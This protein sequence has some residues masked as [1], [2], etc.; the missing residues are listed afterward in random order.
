MISRRAGTAK[1]VYDIGARLLTVAFS[2]FLAIPA[3]GS[4]FADDA[5][6]SRWENRPLAERPTPFDSDEDA[7]FFPALD[8]FL[9]DHF[10]FAL[11]LN[12]WHRQLLFYFFKDSPSRD[13]SL[14]KDGYVFVTS[15]QSAPFS[16]LD[17]LCVRGMDANVA[18]TAAAAW[19]Q[20]LDHFSGMH[21][22]VALIIVPSKPT[23]YPEKLTLS[24]PRRYREA[25]AQYASAQS[26]SG[27]IARAAQANGNRV[28][29]PY[30]EFLRQKYD[31]NFYPRENFHY[32][33]ASAHWVGREVLQQ[34]GIAVSDEFEEKVQ[35]MFRT[36]DLMNLLGFTRQIQAISYP[37]TAFALKKKWGNPSFVLDYYKRAQ[38]SQ[39]VTINSGNPLSSRTALSVGNSFSQNTADNLAPGYR[40]L[41]NVQINDLK[42]EEFV[43]FFTELVP[44]VAANDLIFV[45]NES[46]APNAALSWAAELRRAG[47]LSNASAP[48]QR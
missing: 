1:Y 35:G 38:A 42:K 16:T 10:G 45:F 48:G 20:I 8:R 17:R 3:V 34:L 28:I 44:R 14:G 47:V 2:L 46:V 22:N 21:D 6:R 40:S 29:Y 18:K 25:C 26:I 24:V 30:E 43:P 31:G 32:T 36:Y 27:S 41:I 23:L 11:T 12:R 19:V 9:N 37:Y 15:F 4:L 39:F 7:E 13:I 33:G 5:A